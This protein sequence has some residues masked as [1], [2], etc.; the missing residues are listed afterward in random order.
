MREMVPADTSALAKCLGN[1]TVDVN[2][3]ESQK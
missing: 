2:T 1:N 3:I